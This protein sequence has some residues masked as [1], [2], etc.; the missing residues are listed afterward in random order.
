MLKIPEIW[1][2]DG[3]MLEVLRA[4]TQESKAAPLLTSLLA[5]SLTEAYLEVFGALD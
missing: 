4:I 2:R 3:T 1:I 5:D